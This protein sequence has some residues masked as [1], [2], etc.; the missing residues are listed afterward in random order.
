MFKQV[1][2]FTL[3]LSMFASVIRG[4]TKNPVVPAGVLGDFRHGTFP[5]FGQRTHAGVDLVAACGSPVFAFADGKVVDAITAEVD[6]D[7]KSLGYMVLLKH[8]DDVLD[9]TLYTIYLHFQGAPSVKVGDDVVGGKTK[10]GLVGET[11][12]ALGC[13]THFEARRFTGRFSPEWKNLYG[14]GDVSTSEYFFQS[15]VNPERL[16][17][18]FPHGF[19]RTAY[20]FYPNSI[21]TLS[22]D[23]PV[24]AVAFN[25]DGEFLAVGSGNEISIWSVTS[26]QKVRTLTGHEDDIFSLAFSPDGRFLASG[27]GGAFDYTAR[28]WDYKSGKQLKIL[29]LRGIVEALAFNS[30]GSLLVAAGY[31]RVS[32][33]EVPSGRT[34]LKLPYENESQAV[35]KLSFTADGEHILTGHGDTYAIV[36]S[37]RN[38]SEIRKVG[39]WDDPVGESQ[40]AWN[41]ALV[42]GGSMDG[43]ISVRQID[44]GKTLRSFTGH[45][46]AV[47]G[48]TLHPSRQLIVS[49][50]LD[51]T[52]RLW[53]LD[54]GKA[55]R[56]YRAPRANSG[57]LV[58]SD[59]GNSLAIFGKSVTIW[60]DFLKSLD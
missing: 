25:P 32:I 42:A 36:W 38:G 26:G 30:D 2:I 9:G 13:H 18:T 20:S 56:I 12:F 6:P 34:V 35:S 43:S 53:D 60:K 46:A 3:F 4:E 1:V 45:T 29:D 8:E 22:L 41:D 50:S 57:K 33:H 28:L 54:S 27:S 48:L 5:S 16:F 15:W 49:S 47:R 31:D 37:S 23:K 21:S 40:L 39:N 7:F 17:W 51:G 55:L 59:D 19:N 10:L 14:P 11:G 58:F 52:I 44:S 24:A